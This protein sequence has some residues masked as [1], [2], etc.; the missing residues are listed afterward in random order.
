MANIGVQPHVIEAVIN[1]QSGTKAG[2][3][4]VYNRSPYSA[5]KRIALQR[6]ADHVAALVGDNVVHLQAAK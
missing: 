4:G 3:A 1:H 6:W 2:V 5:E